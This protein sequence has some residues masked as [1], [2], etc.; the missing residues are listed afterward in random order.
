MPKNPHYVIPTCR[1][2]GQQ[3]Y[4]FVA[5]EDKQQYEAYQDAKARREGHIKPPVRWRT[6]QE[7]Q[8]VWGDDL[9]TVERAGDVLWQK[10]D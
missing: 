9:V 10:R 8:R 2:C 4:H 1:K 3:H 6:P 7:G 5:C